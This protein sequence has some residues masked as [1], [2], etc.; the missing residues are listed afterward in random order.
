[1][2]FKIND[3]SLKGILDKVIMCMDTGERI[4]MLLDAE[5]QNVKG[6]SELLT[7]IPGDA[8]K[9]RAALYL[10]NVDLFIESTDIEA[11]ALYILNY[12]KRYKTVEETQTKRA[13]HNGFVDNLEKK[14][15]FIKFNQNK[16][17]INGAE[18]D[19]VFAM[20]RSLIDLL[21]FDKKAMITA[22]RIYP[23]LYG[24]IDN[25]ESASL[26]FAETIADKLTNTLDFYE[27][28]NVILVFVDTLSSH[29]WSLDDLKW[30]I[31][32][33]TEFYIKKS[34]FAV[35]DVVS[36]FTILKYVDDAITYHSEGAMHEYFKHV[37]E[38]VADV[39]KDSIGPKAEESEA[40][41]I[42]LEDLEYKLEKLKEFVFLYETKIDD[43]V[44]NNYIL[45]ILDNCVE[46]LI[47]YNNI[48]AM[49]DFHKSELI[50]TNRIFSEI[51]SYVNK[52][53]VI[54]SDFKNIKEYIKY[55]EDIVSFVYPKFVDVLTEMI[56]DLKIAVIRSKQEL[57]QSIKERTLVP[58]FQF[59]DTGFIL[60]DGSIIPYGDL[61]FDGII[62]IRMYYKTLTD[63]TKIIVNPKYSKVN[64]YK[65]LA[66]LADVFGVIY[67]GHK[68][69]N[70]IEEFIFINEKDFDEYFVSRIFN[71]LLNDEYIS[72]E[73][74]MRL[75]WKNVITYRN[76]ETTAI[77]KYLDLDMLREVSEIQIIN[78]NNVEDNMGDLIIEDFDFSDYT[79]AAL[80]EQVNTVENLNPYQVIRQL[81]NGELNLLKTSMTDL[82]RIYFDTILLLK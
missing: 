30:L 65:E 25:N 16:R 41:F 10:A 69:H 49:S 45:R 80:E 78:N 5:L 20:Y 47:D 63:F 18:S 52:E 64:A 3:I 28:N 4:K 60:D 66:M 67:D 48:Y 38:I 23:N 50:K 32:N 21:K 71:M 36:L 75:N 24:H 7:E 27:I 54:L 43:Y 29:G 8:S 68:I 46:V 59:T 11:D 1:M 53:H 22:G 76:I 70:L 37:K 77:V 55:A 40:L 26:L 19:N 12:E 74:I 51:I 9:I 31:F 15:L 33:E 14:L 6:I 79:F 13:M 35:E 62:T 39:I 44:L 81:I 72:K 34:F 61:R 73:F 2:I 56:A 82:H 57:I 58:V 17:L 42:S